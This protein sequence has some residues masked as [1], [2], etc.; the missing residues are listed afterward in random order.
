MTRGTAGQLAAQV[1]DQTRQLGDG[2]HPAEQVVIGP[3]E[4]RD[5]P[6]GGE[7]REVAAI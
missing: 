2:R 4:R 5:V 3:D 7:P 1:V 6:G